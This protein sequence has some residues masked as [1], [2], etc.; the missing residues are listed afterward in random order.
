[1]D[2][3]F[4]DWI[5]SYDGVEMDLQP[6]TSKIGEYYLT[7]FEPELAPPE[8][9]KRDKLIGETAAAQAAKLSGT[10]TTKLLYMV[11]LTMRRLAGHTGEN[12][13]NFI[14]VV[15]S[16]R[17]VYRVDTPDG[18]AFIDAYTGEIIRTY[19]HRVQ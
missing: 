4:T 14:R 13:F 15:E 8:R 19:S 10:A 12:S 3:G 1:H 6:R 18:G 5:R 9:T 16:W 17:L 11:I 7:R 2:R